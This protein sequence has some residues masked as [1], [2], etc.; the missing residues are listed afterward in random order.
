VCTPG[1]E[2]WAHR[3]LRALGLRTGTPTRGLVPFRATTRQL[4]LANRWVRVPNR[5]LVRIGRFTAATWSELER[6]A[7]RLAWDAHLGEGTAPRFRVTAAKSK[8]IHTDAVAQRLHQLV[9]PPS[10][11]GPE[12]LFV[13]RIN[14][15][16][17]TVSVDTSG[18][19]LHRRGWR[20]QVGPAPLREDLAAAMVLAAGWDGRVPLLDP[21]CGAGT[22]PI[23]AARLAAGFPPRL[24][25]TYAFQRWPS[26]EPG[27]WASVLADP[28][29]GGC[30][31]GDPAP[32]W[33]SDRDGAMTAATVANAE[34]AGVADRITA[35][36]RVVSHLKA[37]RGAGVVVTNPPYGRRTGDPDRLARLYARFGA[38]ARQRLPGYGV[39]LLAAEARLAAATGLALRPLAT[40]SNG[41]L[42]VQLFAAA[43]AAAV[44]SGPGPGGWSAAD[45]DDRHPRAPQL[46]APVDTEPAP[47]AGQGRQQG[48]LAGRVRGR[49]AGRAGAGDGEAGPPVGGEGEGPQQQVAARGAP[50]GGAGGVEVE[51]DGPRV[52]HLDGGAGVD[53]GRGPGPVDDPA[54]AGAQVHGGGVGRPPRPAVG[55][56][57]QAGRDA[58]GGDDRRCGSGPPRPQR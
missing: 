42:R 15:D 31:R 27:T 26:F 36:T 2:T 30:G 14:H 7:S 38:V 24:E 11:G 25:R 46:E 54:G 41:G 29:P 51:G 13:V 9:G 20:H 19:A 33:A 55:R 37:R 3:E 57:Q 50:Q 45:Q 12:Q 40:T 39:V 32:I 43:P 49:A 35:E 16:L 21:F 4:Y 47:G 44:R 6:G 23:E 58:S 17:V 10:P 28:A 52:G 8:L 1:L 22:I 34:R 53:A 48:F 18:E 56:Q 5:V